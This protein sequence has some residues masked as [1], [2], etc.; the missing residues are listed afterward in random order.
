[1]SILSITFFL[2]RFHPLVVHLPIGFI[3]LAVIL[4]WRLSKGEPSKAI[5]Y[6]WLLSAITSGVAA[7]MGWFLAN[8][9]AYDNWTL[10]AHR[11]LG[12]IIGLIS[13]Y[14]WYIRRDKV[15]SRLL[16]RVTSIGALLIILIT[17]H[18]GGNLTHGSD[19][20]LEHAPGP[21]QS[22]FGY[23]KV[24]NEYPQYDN[25]NN[26]TVYADL[27]RPTL[28]QKC[29]S[30]HNEDVQNGGLNMASVEALTKGGEGGVVIVPGD[31]RSE[32]L[33]RVTMPVSSS[34]F[35]PTSGTMMTY[36]EVKLLEWWI[37]QGADYT[38]KANE[39]N[40]PSDITKTVKD[41]YGLD[42]TSR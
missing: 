4:E 6:A 5:S 37:A 17:G 23:G 30:C 16:R 1:M 34:K 8:E 31:I 2:G 11:W 32:L 40:T 24:T 41:L 39:I 9:G 15:P 21:I 7:L 33:K 20:L 29:W 27:I 28:E 25:P 26:V 13:L 38:A 19:Y 12:I 10:F 35:M 22:L 14:A 18:L 36:H 3:L 42:L